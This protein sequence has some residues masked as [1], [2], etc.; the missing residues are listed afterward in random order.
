MKPAPSVP[1]DFCRYRAWRSSCVLSQRARQQICSLKVSVF[2]RARN[3][4]LLRCLVRA[5]TSLSYAE[6]RVSACGGIAECGS[7]FLCS[8]R[9]TFRDRIHRV[10]QLPAPANPRRLTRVNIALHNRASLSQARHSSE[11]LAIRDIFVVVGAP[12]E[13]EDRLGWSTRST[14]TCTAGSCPRTPNSATYST[15]DRGSTMNSRRARRWRSSTSSLTFTPSSTSCRVGR[16]SSTNRPS[17]GERNSLPNLSLFT[18]HRDKKKGNVN[19][20]C[21]RAICRIRLV[22]GVYV[23]R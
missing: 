20:V 6:C 3:K 13:K 7:S 21:L 9:R 14:W 10:W 2:E 4:S 1:I 5:A 23:S 16:S 19:R 17:T 11:K 12:S 22:N 18:R 8:E 15:D